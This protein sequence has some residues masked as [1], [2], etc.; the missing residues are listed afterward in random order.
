MKNALEGISS[1][2]SALIT[3]RVYVKTLT[4][5]FIEIQTRFDITVEEIKEFVR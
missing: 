2:S 3:G 4:G 1:L 5:K